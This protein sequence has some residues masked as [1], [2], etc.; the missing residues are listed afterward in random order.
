M[1]C[2]TFLM[3]KW[4]DARIFTRQRSSRCCD[5]LSD[6]NNYIPKFYKSSWKNIFLS[7]IITDPRKVCSWHPQ[8]CFGRI[9][10]KWSTS[11]LFLNEKIKAETLWQ[12][13]ST[14]FLIKMLL[15]SSYATRKSSVTL[16]VQI[17]HCF[18]QVTCHFRPNDQLPRIFPKTEFLPTIGDWRWVTLQY[19]LMLTSA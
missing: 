19:C 5:M 9:Q 11:Y 17:C 4:G 8:K 12:K 16:S 13:S 2:E 15:F 1:R 7:L 6:N 3:Y 14:D 18:A 10:N